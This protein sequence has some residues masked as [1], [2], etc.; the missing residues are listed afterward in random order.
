[1]LLLTH[2][3]NMPSSGFPVTGSAA[4]TAPTAKPLS[5]LPLCVNTDALYFGLYGNTTATGTT[6]DTVGTFTASTGTV[7]TRGSTGLDILG[8]WLFSLGG[9]NTAG[10]TPTFSGSLRYISNQTS[11][12]DLVLLTAMNVSTDSH[13]IWVDRTWK[14]AGQ[15]NSTAN[16]LRSASAASGTGLKQNG[17]RMLAVENYM[18]SD[19]APLHPLRPWVDDGLN[20]LTNVR[21]YGEF[22]FTSPFLQELA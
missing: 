15:L 2:A 3:F 16:A 13:M 17:A 11:T 10:N 6:G 14:K 18:I 22:V 1:M 12:T 19:H 20:G 9:V 21:L 8:G 5:Y 7:V 4:T